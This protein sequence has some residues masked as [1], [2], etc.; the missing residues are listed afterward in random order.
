MPLIVATS[1]YLQL[2]KVGHKPIVWNDKMNEIWWCGTKFRK[3][4][5]TSAENSHTCSIT[6]I[7]QDILVKNSLRKDI[8]GATNIA[9]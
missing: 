2:P 9:F 5:D 7:Q 3:G 4:L 1:F 6:D 8:R